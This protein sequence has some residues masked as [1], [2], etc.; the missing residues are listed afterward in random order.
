MQVA[1]KEENFPY[2]KEYMAPADTAVDEEGADERSDSLEDDKGEDG[3]YIC[4]L[5]TL[6]S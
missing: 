2:P 4:T 1:V 3:S 5:Q 6:N